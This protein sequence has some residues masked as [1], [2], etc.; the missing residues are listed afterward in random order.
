MVVAGVAELPATFV[1]TTDT[2]YVVHGEPEASAALA[3]RLVEVAV[4]AVVPNRY[5]LVR[6]D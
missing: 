2:V 3:V 6:L 4:N 5:E 1:A